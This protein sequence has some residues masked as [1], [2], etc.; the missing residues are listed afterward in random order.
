MDSGLASASH[1][2]SAQADF[3]ALTLPISGKPE[4]GGAPE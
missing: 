3:M 1:Q 2:K 4:I